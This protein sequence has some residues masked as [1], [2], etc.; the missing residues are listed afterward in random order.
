MDYNVACTLAELEP[1]DCRRE[2]ICLKFAK[3]D[4]KKENSV[5]MK[6]EAAVSTRNPKLVRE[7]KCNTKRFQ[8]SSIPYLSKLL[9]Q[10]P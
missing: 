7:P 10:N 5:F 9:N 4:F 8:K 1:L 3:K 6:N 2:Q